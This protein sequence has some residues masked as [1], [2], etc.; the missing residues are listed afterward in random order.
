MKRATVILGVILGILPAGSTFAVRTIY[1]ADGGSADFSTIQA[2]IDDANEGDVIV[3]KPGTYTGDGNRDI[4]FRGK[5]ITVRSENGPQ[6]CTIDCQATEQDMHR[7]FVFQNHEGAN[8]VLCGVTITG[9]FARSGGAVFCAGRASPVIT[10]CVIF[11]NSAY[12]GGGISTQEG[13]RSSPTIVNCVITD[14]R[15]LYRDESDLFSYGFGGG[16][17]LFG[18]PFHW[19]DCGPP[20]GACPTISNCTIIGNIAESTGGGISCASSCEVTVENSIVRGNAAIE[21]SEDQNVGLALTAD[22]CNPRCKVSYSNLEDGL[23]GIG[24][25]YFVDWGDGN[26]DT[27]PAFTDPN[28]N[29]YHLKSQAGRWDPN[30]QSW[31]Q[32]DMTSPCIDAG[33]PMSPI[34]LEPFPNGGIVNMG[35]YGG[36]AEASKSYFGGPMCKA[37]VA[38]DINGDCKVDFKDIAI[39]MMHWLRPPDQ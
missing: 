14:N 7:G 28:N 27:D 3:I 20:Y 4:D 8:S 21:S 16:V 37:I 6:H 36:T 23:D 33:D 25:Y 17:F 11:G 31:V 34:G 2:A 32:D 9:G 18:S 13:G 12:Q 26:I 30:G 24:T 1:V 38:G 29:D 5:A 19:L 35:A 15:A 22:G 39:M 10:S